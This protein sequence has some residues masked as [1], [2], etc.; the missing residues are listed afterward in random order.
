MADGLRGPTGKANDLE[1][2]SPEIWP[3]LLSLILMK[4]QD[5]SPCGLNLPIYKLEIITAVTYLKDFV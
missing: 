5:T 1:G 2:W 3:Q 4:G